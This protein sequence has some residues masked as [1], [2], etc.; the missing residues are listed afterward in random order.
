[1]N[2]YKLVVFDF[3]GTLAD[4]FACF[5]STINI[6]AER[7]RF[8]PIEPTKLDEL[9]RC[10][11]HQLMA[12]LGL[13]WWK[14]PLVARAMRRLM[15]ARIDEVKLFDGVDWLFLALKQAEL[16][17]AIVTSNSEAYVRQVLGDTK[18]AQLAYLF[19][20]ATLFGKKAKLKSL[21]QKSKLS[22]REILCVGDESRDAEAAASM[23][24]D[25]IGVSWGYTNPAE[26]QRHVG[27]MLCNEMCDVLSFALSPNVAWTLAS[28][29]IAARK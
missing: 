3:D 20:D 23:G 7:F 15:L 13:S 9:G 25:F 24:M 10:N 4:S 29:P 14:I 8:S 18:I 12:C 22:S 5:I 19:C 26:L 1:M 16:D 6:A 21:L 27:P 11:A 2:Q 28:S 17:I